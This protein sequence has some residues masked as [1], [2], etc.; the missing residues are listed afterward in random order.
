MSNV[1]AEL[2][3]SEIGPAGH[4]KIAPSAAYD[5]KIRNLLLEG[6]IEE[7]PDNGIGNGDEADFIHFIGDLGVFIDLNELGSSSDFNNNRCA[8]LKRDS[9][10][11][12]VGTVTVQMKNRHYIKAVGIN[13]R[14]DDLS[15]FIRLPFI[16]VYVCDGEY[17]CRNCTGG[18]EGINLLGNEGWNY[19]LCEEVGSILKIEV[20]LPEDD[21]D[22]S[23]SICELS[24]FGLDV[25]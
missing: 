14:N 20:N 16:T 19:V 11:T 1:L 25:F 18:A 17:I 21:F 3:P 9:K 6:H 2:E 10:A 22:A 5:I 23:V 24:L 4:P 13:T 7:E 8:E 12:D 15:E